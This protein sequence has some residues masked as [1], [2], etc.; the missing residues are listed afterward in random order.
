MSVF[1]TGIKPKDLN[2]NMPIIEVVPIVR[3]KDC[4]YRPIDTGGH[5]Y[6]QDLSFPDD[7]KCP[8][9]CEDPWYSWMPPDDWFCANGKKGEK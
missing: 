4:T 5:N 6:G 1:I 8:C 3:C 2:R 7:Y 9:R